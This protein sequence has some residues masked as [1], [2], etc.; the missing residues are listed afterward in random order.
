MPQP[1]ASIPAPLHPE[2]SLAIERVFRA[3]LEGLARDIKRNYHKGM[4]EC[5][6]DP[7]E[8][9]HG[10]DCYR[11]FLRY[12]AAENS[13]ISAVRGLVRA[14]TPPGGTARVEFPTSKFTCR[15]PVGD[16]P[17]TAA[18]TEIG[19]LLNDDLTHKHRGELVRI[20][21]VKTPNMRTWMMLN[22]G[23]LLWQDDV[24]KSCMA[25]G[26]MPE[27]AWSE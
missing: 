21:R 13:A 17:Y 22:Q 10:A 16:C 3:Y 11:A 27:F 2:V 26:D 20:T 1:R 15:A 7:Y 4:C 12:E 5:L 25:G 14:K 19:E 18:W 24:F 6:Q 8:S 23:A 9:Y